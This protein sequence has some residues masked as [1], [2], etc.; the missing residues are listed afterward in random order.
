MMVMAA[1]DRLSQVRYVGQLAA[2]AGVAKIRRELSELGGGRGISVRCRGFRCA[3]QVGGNLLGDLLV[4]G[5]VRLLQLLQLAHN[6]GERRKL[7]AIRL[8]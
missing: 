8:L 1:A 2:L 5:R 3:L 7:T 4:L 6:L